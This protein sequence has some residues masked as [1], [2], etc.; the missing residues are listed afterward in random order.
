MNSSSKFSRICSRVRLD[1]MAFVWWGGVE[2]PHS[3]L[4]TTDMMPS[5]NDRNLFTSS[6]LSD[7]NRS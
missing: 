1:G 4:H 2:L 6:S 3:P 7:N 5:C